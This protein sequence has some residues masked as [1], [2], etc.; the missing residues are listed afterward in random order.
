M[1]LSGKMAVRVNEDAQ[2]VIEQESGFGGM[3]SIEPIVLSRAESLRLAEQ[4]Q[5]AR[6]AEGEPGVDHEKPRVVVAADGTRIRVVRSPPWSPG[7]DSW[8]V[9]LARGRREFA[10]PNFGGGVEGWNYE[11][12]DAQVLA[13]YEAWRKAAEE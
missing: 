7:D 12:T 8:G 10:G 5:E 9:L 6:R 2:V 3:L 4:V 13:E 11:P 1:R